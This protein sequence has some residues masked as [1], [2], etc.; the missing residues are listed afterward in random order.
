MIISRR[1]G[2]KAGLA[3]VL[4]IGFSIVLTLVGWLHFSVA[5]Q[6][7]ESQAST[8][9]ATAWGK[10][11]A[12]DGTGFYNEI[13]GDVLKHVSGDVAYQI[14]PYR[15]AKMNFF[16]TNLGCLYPSSLFGLTKAGQIKDPENYIESNGLFA[17]RTHLFVRRGTVPPANL[18]DLAGKSIAYPSGSI[19]AD[20]LAGYGARLIGVNSEQDKAEMLVSGRVDMI[21]GMMPDTAIVFADMGGEMPAFDPLL[22]L[23]EVAVTFVCHRTQQNENL[24][25]SVNKVLEDLQ[26]DP[27]YRARMAAAVSAQDV[28][29]QGSSEA[30]EA[31]KKK[32]PRQNRGGRR[33][34]MHPSR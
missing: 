12:Q 23:Y 1:V 28:L 14:M 20:V 24:I 3:D 26:Q 4:R 34:P 25:I 13:A 8:I 5:L 19:A 9:Y 22:V 16:K 7:M 32:R 30:P 27:V 18:D 2:C 10:T 29:L 6:G 11:L 17:A 15:R 21:T 31:N 33:L